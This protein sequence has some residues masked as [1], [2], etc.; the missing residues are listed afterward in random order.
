MPDLSSGIF[1]LSIEVIKN[2]GSGINEVKW[3][4]DIKTGKW[5][6]A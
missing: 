2:F 1:I 6:L 4:P 3:P 5:V